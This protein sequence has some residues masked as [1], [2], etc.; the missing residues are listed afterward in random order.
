MTSSPIKLPLFAKAF[1]SLMF[2]ILGFSYLTLLGHIYI[3]TAFKISQIIGAYKHMGFE[4]MDPYSFIY[5]H[6][7]AI[8]FSL[9]LA[10]FFLTNNAKKLK[11]L[12]GVAVPLLITTDTASMWLIPLWDGFVYTLCAAG[13]LLAF[14]FLTMFLLTQYDFWIRKY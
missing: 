2:C 5:V 13:F 10:A 14:S 11:W 6:W 3:G 4:E 9:T 12:F 8:T 7:Y 1:I